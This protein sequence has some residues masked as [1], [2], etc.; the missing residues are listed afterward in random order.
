MH[1]SSHK[2]LVCACIC[3]T[4]VLLDAHCAKWPLTQDYGC[5]LSLYLL[6]TKGDEVT[7]EWRKLHIGELHNLY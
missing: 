1:C 6:L 4:L 3:F 7:G 5:R 2:S